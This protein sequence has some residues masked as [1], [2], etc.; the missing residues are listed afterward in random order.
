MLMGLVFAVSPVVAVLALRRATLLVVRAYLRRVAKKLRGE[1]PILEGGIGG[2][3][4][5]AAIPFG[6]DPE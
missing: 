1:R 3:A 5:P 6:G 2:S 4:S